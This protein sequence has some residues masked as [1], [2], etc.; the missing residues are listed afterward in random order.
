[1]SQLVLGDMAKG[2]LLHYGIQNRTLFLPLYYILVV[3]RMQYSES[4]KCPLSAL[5]YSAKLH[6]VSLYALSNYA[7]VPAITNPPIH[8][9]GWFTRFYAR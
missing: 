6:L 7:E 4:R 3:I 5:Y 9:N 1:M 8:F 2:Q